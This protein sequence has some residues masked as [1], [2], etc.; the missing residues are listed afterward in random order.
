MPG[1][2]LRAELGGDGSGFDAMLR[3]ANTAKDKFASSFAGL[4]TVI[5]GAFTVGAIT[6]FTRQTIELAGSLRDVS[7]E[8]GVNVEWFQRLRNGAALTGG[9]IEDVEK[10]ISEMNKSREDAINNPTGKNARAFGRLGMDGNDLRGLSS[11]QFMDK[12]VLAFKNGMTTQM[13]ND[14]QEVGGKSARNLLAAFANQFES[15]APIITEDVVDQL[16]AVGDAF[17]E[18]GITIQSSFA[19]VLAS[20][21][22]LANKFVGKIDLFRNG[23]ASLMVALNN[24][25]LVESLFVRRIGHRGRIIKPNFD[26]GDAIKTF[27]EVQRDTETE[28]AAQLES[29]QRAREAARGARRLRENSL[30]SFAEL[31]AKITHGPAARIIQERL[32]PKPTDS[33]VGVGN[34]L[35]RNPQLVNVVANQQLLVARQSLTALQEIFKVLA[36]NPLTKPLTGGINVPTV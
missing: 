28:L 18:L 6:N 9:K 8:L 20:L 5:A 10:F 35:G 3:R 12:L 36:A 15:T 13:A 2:K 21:V 24:K 7:D 32:K 22:E 4:K 29:R 23:L 34:F 19:P 31:G 16:D 25:E 30:P 27:E 33:L 11:M 17:T 1:L 26:I 14:L